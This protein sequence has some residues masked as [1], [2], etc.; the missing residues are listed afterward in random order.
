MLCLEPQVVALIIFLQLVGIM[1]SEYLWGPLLVALSAALI[2]VKI[3][4]T[5]FEFA[6]LYFQ[7]NSQSRECIHIS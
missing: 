5:L 4:A 7:S 1:L 2:M 3:R 6:A